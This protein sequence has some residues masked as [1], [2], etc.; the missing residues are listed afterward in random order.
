MLKPLRK[1][2]EI[3][4]NKMQSSWWTSSALFTSKTKIAFHT[5]EDNQ[6]VEERWIMMVSHTGWKGMKKV[7]NFIE[8]FHA[9]TH[10][11]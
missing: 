2:K 7:A 10:R 5:A 6:D 1:A 11:V 8:T 4:E 9:G 3:S